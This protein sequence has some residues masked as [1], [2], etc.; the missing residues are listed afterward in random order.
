MHKNERQTLIKQIITQ[1][2]IRT[3]EE[4]LKR[5]QKE[6]I[7]IA[8]ATISRDIRD[9]KIIKTIDESG[10]PK[11]TLYDSTQK[12]NE[13]EQDKLINLFNDIVTKIEH[14]QFL[15]IIHTLPD[16]ASLLAAM[17]DEVHLPK[18]KCTLAGFDTVVLIVS[19]ETHAIEMENYFNEIWQAQTNNQL[20]S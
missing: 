20:E 12:Q 6:D 17:I 15:T 14:V 10:R 1:Y 5:L 11:F 16:N 9:L 8:Q 7:A 19:D 13:E 3:Q 18:V 2:T 4:L